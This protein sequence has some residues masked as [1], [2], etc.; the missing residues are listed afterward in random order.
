MRGLLA[1]I[2]LLDQGAGA[3]EHPIVLPPGTPPGV[4]PPPQPSHP[5][6]PP[7]G[8]PPGGGAPGYPTHPIEPPSGAAPGHPIYIPGAPPGAPGSPTHPIYLPVYPS[9]PIA[10]VPGAPPGSP[11]HP[12]PPTPE[13][14]WVPPTGGDT[15]PIDPGYFPPGV[16]VPVPPEGG[17]TATKAYI[18]AY[19]PGQGR[20]TFLVDLP[21]PTVPTEPEPKE[22]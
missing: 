3:P 15:A 7:I 11:T 2:I 18:V 5:W 14:P 21:E 13:H 16:A 12:I 9:H 22:E 19:V 10:G 1:Y 8:T 20:M 17:G 6:L 4:W